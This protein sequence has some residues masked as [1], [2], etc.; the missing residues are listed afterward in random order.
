MLIEEVKKL[1]PLDRFIYWIEERTAIANKRKQGLPRPWTN[2]KI[3]QTVF[4]THAYRE[5]DKTTVWFRENIRNPLRD[6][7]AVIFA[8]ICFRW[9]NYIPTGKVLVD[10]KLYTH[11]NKAKAIEVL[12]R[13]PKV[14]TGAFM[15]PAVPGTKKVNHVC[16][17]LE[18]AWRI[19]DDLAE[20]IVGK[21]LQKAHTRLKDIKWLGNF[22]SYEVVTD[23]R[24]TYV[25]EN[26]PDI[27][28]WANPG[29]GCI[30]GLR[31]LQGLPLSKKG[32]SD[33]LPRPEG[34]QRYM[35]DLLK[36]VQERLPHLPP[37]EMHEVE[38]VLCEIDKYERVLWGQ[39]KA[40]RIY[41]GR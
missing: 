22:M 34:W 17:C 8:T 10:Y 30:R 25:L 35:Q 33:C 16:T 13:L 9:F 37:F 19:R 20:D 39:G 38:M 26:A 7:P 1:S 12:S 2:D 32:N 40:K 23:L 41:N 6:L 3:L 21:S 18:A 15:I 29:P 31:R 28:T 14:F 4:F 27:M 5:D 24:H 36:T 11:W